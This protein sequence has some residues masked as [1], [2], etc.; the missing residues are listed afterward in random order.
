[1]TE[2][3]LRNA[4]LKEQYKQQQ[5]AGSASLAQASPQGEAGASFAY[6]PSSA[7]SQA[8][9]YLASL[10]K[11]TAQEFESP[12]TQQ[13]A[14]LY[15]RIMNRQKFSYDP[16][17]DPLFQAYKNQY[18]RQGQQAA[19]NVIGQSAALTG[20]YGNTWA[21]TAGS[22]AY[23]NYLTRLNEILPQ[24]EARAYERYTGEGD[25]LQSQLSLAS[26]LENQDYER[27]RTALEDWQ[28]NQKSSGGTKKNDE[29]T[30]DKLNI[31]EGLN[32]SKKR[33]RVEAL[34]K[35][36]SSGDS[37]EDRIHDALGN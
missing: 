5:G 20:G 33:K 27:F 15:E 19:Q 12:Y 34:R 24:M 25:Q 8:Q 9:N 4:Q 3:E 21:A 32:D 16:T 13:V 22:Q 29:N 26:A 14:S 18:V 36:Q 2:E 23:Q 1:M 31:W 35:R 28:A 17:K 37:L 11:G 7:V 30:E 6:T 10:K